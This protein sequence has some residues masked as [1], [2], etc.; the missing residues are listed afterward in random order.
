MTSLLQYLDKVHD[1]KSQKTKGVLLKKGVLKNVSKFTGKY[2]D[3]FFCRGLFFK[4]A[5]WRPATTLNR[6]FST[7]ASL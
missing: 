4:G 2:L 7:S 3:L 1:L 5:G 6:V